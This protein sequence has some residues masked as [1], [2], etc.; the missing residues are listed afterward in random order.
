MWGIAWLRWSFKGDR[1]KR[2]R[3]IDRARALSAF[4]LSDNLFYWATP[5]R[6]AFG[7]RHSR[8][9]HPLADRR[10]MAGDEGLRLRIPVDA[11]LG[12]VGA[13][14]A[15]AWRARPHLRHAGHVVHRHAD[16]G[17]GRP[18]H[19][20]LPDRALPA[21]AAPADRHRG[22]T[23]RRHSLDHLRHVGLLR[24]R[25]VPGQHLPAVHDQHLRGRAGAGRD[26][27][28]PAVLSQPV[29]RRADPGDHG[30][31]VHHRG[32]ARTCSTPCRRC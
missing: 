2:R 10:R 21:V 7:A 9:H 29:Q 31:A 14:A 6:R 23:A 13:A 15:G 8:R 18:R 30:A 11:A 27:R 5:H 12:A 28:R 1:W 20:D 26:L 3:H 17:S 19:R 25:A 22:R 16:R 24:A 4:K 32:L